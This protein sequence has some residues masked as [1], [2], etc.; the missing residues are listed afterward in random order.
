MSAVERPGQSPGERIRFV[1][2]GSKGYNPA[3]AGALVRHTARADNPPRSAPQCDDA[4]GSRRHQTESV[5]QSA[6]QAVQLSMFSLYRAPRVAKPPRLLRLAAHVADMPPL[7]ALLGTDL[8]GAPLLIRLPAADVGHLLIRG[9]IQSGKTALARTIATSLAMFTPASSLQ[10]ILIDPT[11]KGFGALCALPHVLGNLV[12][13]PQETVDCLRWVGREMVR[14]ER[15]PDRSHALVVFIDRLEELL[16]VSPARMQSLLAQLTLR[17]GAVGIHIVACARTDAL[18]DEMEDMEAAFR[19]HVA[20][21]AAEPDDWSLAGGEP[22]RARQVPG[23]IGEFTLVM[24]S[25]ALP[26]RAAWIG[27]RE[28]QEVAV[29]LH[30]DADDPVDWRAFMSEP[31][32]GAAANPPSDFGN[33]GNDES[34]RGVPG[35]A[36]G[37]Y[38]AG[39]AR[40]LRNLLAML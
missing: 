25:E 30:A 11:R 13:T 34:A 6:C 8:S 28:L 36:P 31:E 12:S 17:A 19:L 5:E 26:F 3:T 16:A 22:G 39:A 37:R 40:F 2:T 20:G 7:T 10:L 35:A 15:S 23:R 9:R 32:L 4:D 33:D 29:L 24:G 27:R 21:P 38:G 14:R 18:T 1:L